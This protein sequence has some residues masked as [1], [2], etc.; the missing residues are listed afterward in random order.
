MT[1]IPNERMRHPNARRRSLCVVKKNQLTPNYLSI[2]FSCDDF[3]DFHSSSADDHIKIFLT[4]ERS[5]EGKP[6]MRDYTPRS[7]DADKCEFVIDF[8][9]HE[10][11]GPATAWAI[12]SMIGDSLEIGGPRGSVMISDAYDW[13]WLIGDETAIPAIARRMEE[14]PNAKMDIWVAVE[15]ESEEVELPSSAS[16]SVNYVHRRVEDAHDPASLL[17]AL[18]GQALP[19]GNGFIWIAAEGSVVKSLRT[20]MTD[21]GHPLKQM[22]AAGYWVHGQADAKESFND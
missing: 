20:A 4:G 3:E 18:S 15:N 8:A 9:L 5:A 22:K 7:F 14:W 19:D 16:H 1:L 10:D 2:T 21:K 17:S 12:G 6:P 13:Y 11:P